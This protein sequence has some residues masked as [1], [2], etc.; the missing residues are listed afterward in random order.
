MNRPENL[1]KRYGWCRKKGHGVFFE[2]DR[3]CP[4]CLTEAQR[5]K[6]GL[7]CARL[8]HGPGH[9]S[10]TYCQEKGPHKVHSCVYGIY[11]SEAFWTGP[12]NKEKFTGYF[13]EP[14]VE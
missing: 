6:D 14:P 11:D 9:Q 3:G 1:N 12:K 4:R 13:D 8:S 7:C 5:K 2:R 10:H